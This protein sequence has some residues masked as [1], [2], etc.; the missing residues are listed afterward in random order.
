MAKKAVK[1]K[2]AGAGSVTK[3][4]YH[5]EVQVN[6][7]VY[8]GE[9]GSLDQALADFVKSQSF[10]ETIKTRVVIKFGTKDA[11]SQV[12]W[13]VIKARRQFNLMTLKPYWAELVADKFGAN[14]NG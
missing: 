1:A 10:P 12:V 5:L 11:E 6:D 3:K 8:K 9:A 14:L 7:I 2:K 13:P 4:A